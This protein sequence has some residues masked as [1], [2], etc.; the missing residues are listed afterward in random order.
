MKSD[1]LYP[2]SII[3]ILY[4]TY[5]NYQ[6]HYSTDQVPFLVILK[7]N[8]LMSKCY[9]RLKF[10]VNYVQSIKKLKN[11]EIAAVSDMR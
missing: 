5:I 8:D 10:R 7:P 11:M 2:S 4:F 6:L 1:E 9:G 3:I